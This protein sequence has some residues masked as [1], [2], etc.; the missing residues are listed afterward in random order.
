MAN[1][2]AQEN[3]DSG[4]NETGSYELVHQTLKVLLR[5]YSSLQIVDFFF[6]FSEFILHCGEPYVRELCTCA[7]NL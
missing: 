6:F 3:L 2:S 1:E 5:D 7:C 4:V